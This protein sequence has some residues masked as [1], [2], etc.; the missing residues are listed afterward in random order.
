MKTTFLLHGG[1]LKY[2]DPR[3]D[4]YFQE[5]TKDLKD[6]DAVLHIAFARAISRRL[7]TCET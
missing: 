3:N 4:A 2:Q 6:G 7:R 1:K 5:L